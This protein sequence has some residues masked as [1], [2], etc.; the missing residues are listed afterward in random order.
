MQGYAGAGVVAKV[1]NPV[2][3]SVTIFIP[4]SC[5]TVAVVGFIKCDIDIT[6]ITY[7]NLPGAAYRVGHHHGLETARQG[8]AAVVFR[9][10]EVFS[11]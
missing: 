1:F 7:R 11:I 4:E 2:G 6:I 8:N 3:H 5:D 9:K 10:G